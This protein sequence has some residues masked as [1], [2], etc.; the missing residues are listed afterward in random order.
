MTRAPALTRCRGRRAVG[1]HGG[2]APRAP[3]LQLVVGSRSAASASCLAYFE[4][5]QP[6][7]GRGARGA[8]RRVREYGRGRSHSRR[9]VRMAPRSR[10]GSAGR[11]A[12]VLAPGPA[13]SGTC[14]AGFS[15]PPRPGSATRSP[16]RGPAYPSVVRWL[17]GSRRQGT[18]C[19]LVSFRR[20]RA[21]MRQ[22]S[23]AHAPRAARADPRGAPRGA[24]PP[25]PVE[26]FLA[27]SDLLSE[28][29]GRRGR[30]LEGPLPVGGAECAWTSDLA[31]PREALPQPPAS[32]GGG[33][34]A[35]GPVVYGAAF[36][37]RNRIDLQYWI[38]YPYNVYSPTIP[39]GDL[40]QVHEGTGRPCRS[41]STC[42]DSL[43]GRPLAPQ[44]G[45]TASMGEGGS[46]GLRP[47]VYVGL[48]SHANFFEPGEHRLDPRFVDPVLISVIEA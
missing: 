24:P 41:S 43:Y 6:Y 34:H 14:R 2:V 42:A 32:V 29:S 13:S 48:G 23:L 4:L 12:R 9:R 20:G 26:G 1:R 44:R 40:W 35:P 5:V 31:M 7:F 15:P 33:A 18:T 36:R 28:D 22:P 39:A 17:A 3:A 10:A 47:L 45:R 21:P 25:G 38:W 19:N 16:R 30:R 46:R 37:T 8:R 27:D 11:R